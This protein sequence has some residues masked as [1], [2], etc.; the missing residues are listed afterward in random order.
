LVF[1]SPHHLNEPER[2]WDSS[3][4]A[5]AVARVISTSGFGWATPHTLRRTVATL[6]DQAGVPIA[7]MPVNVVVAIATPEASSTVNVR[8]P[9]V[10]GFLTYGPSGSKAPNVMGAFRASSGPVYR[11]V[12]TP[13]WLVSGPLPSPPHIARIDGARYDR[14]RME[15]RMS[16]SGT[17]AKV[18]TTSLLMHCHMCIREDG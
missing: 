15:P 8:R 4:S 7:R 11:Y 10:D 6:L 17:H 5:K 18:C 14:A 3:N 1:S 16:D 13:D 9:Q 12:T 2:R